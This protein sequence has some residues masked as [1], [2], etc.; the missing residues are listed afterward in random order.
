[1]KYT[2]VRCTLL[3]RCSCIYRA[4]HIYD[5]IIICP[6]FNSN[7]KYNETFIIVLRCSSFAFG[8][9]VKT[10]MMYTD[11][12][13]DLGGCGGW[14]SKISCGGT[15]YT[16]VPPIFRKHYIYRINLVCHTAC[17]VESTQSTRKIRSNGELTKKV[18]KRFWRDRPNG[19]FSCHFGLKSVIG[20]FGSKHFSEIIFGPL[21]T[22]D[23]VAVHVYRPMGSNFEGDIKL[24]VNNFIY[25]FLFIIVWFRI[26]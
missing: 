15:V 16:F 7:Q 23:Q 11:M 26:Y 21:Q 19:K 13:G 5:I 1:M 18:F 12:G 22:Q 10:V 25:F 9:P 8:N 3:K 14:P 2:V 24:S 6:S 20:N 4:M 17:S